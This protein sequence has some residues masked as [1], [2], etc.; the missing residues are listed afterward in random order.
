MNQNETSR[1]IAENLSRLM[2]EKG[3]NNSELSDIIGVSD[4]TVGKWLLMKAVPRMGVIEKLASYFN[5]SKS[6]ILEEHN[7]HK[8]VVIPVMGTIPA[9]IPIDAIEEVIDHEEI[10]AEIARTG[11]FFG[12]KIRGDS[13]YPRILDGDVVIVKKQNYASPKDVVIVL[14][15]GNEATCKQYFRY[16]DHIEFVPFNPMYKPLK[17]NEKDIEELPVRIIGKVVELRGKF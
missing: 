14:I 2:E 6:D 13:M 9:G 17:F 11:E 5:I 7:P 3:I 16:D 12:L 8:G 1:I 15:N 4:S 10:S